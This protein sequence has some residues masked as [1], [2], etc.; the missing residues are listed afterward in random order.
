VLNREEIDR[1]GW[2][3][4]DEVSRW[5]TERPEEFASALLFIWGKLKGE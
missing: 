4:K 5:M 1:G 2:F 3:S